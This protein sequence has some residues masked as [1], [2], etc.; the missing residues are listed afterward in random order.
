MT[1]SAQEIIRWG[2]PLVKIILLVLVVTRR[3]FSGR[4]WLVAYLAVDLAVSLVWR[5]PRL[6]AESP[7]F[8]VSRFYEVWGPPLNIISLVAYCLLVPFILAVAD[9]HSSSPRTPMTQR[10]LSIS[11][12][13]WVLIVIGSVSLITT[14][15]MINNPTA[16]DIMAQNPMP[17]PIQYA[18]SYLGLAIMIVS[19]AAMLKGRN[20]ARYLYVISSLIVFALGFATSPIKATL[21]P[22][23]VVFLVVAFLLFRPKANAFFTPHGDSEEPYDG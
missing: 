10:P 21:I 9:S 13:S 12:I 16:R 11:I 4:P 8:D 17:L 23:F 6:L 15:A 18:M 7:S 19:G 5:L 14:T 3:N 20:W 22:G 1:E 2:F